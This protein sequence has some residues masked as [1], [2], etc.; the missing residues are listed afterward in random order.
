[1]LGARAQGERAPARFHR[2]AREIQQHLLQ[3]VRIAPHVGQAGVIVVAQPRRCGFGAHELGEPV[4]QF[5]DVH[6]AKP[7]RAVAMQQAI[8]QRGE[9]VGLVDDQAGQRLQLDAVDAPLQQLRRTAQ[10]GQRILHLVREAAQRGRQRRDGRRRRGQ[11]VHLDQQF[12]IVRGLDRQIGLE[13][14][15]VERGQRRLAQLH[16]ACLVQ[17]ALHLGQVL[18]RTQPQRQRLADRAAHAAA[19]QFGQRG[20]DPAHAQLRVDQGHPGRQLFQSA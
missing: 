3:L 5:V 6:R 20:I 4:Q 13:R 1:M 12:A 10:A 18:R 9:A 19:Q 7:R 14:A 15:L 17:R 2:V 11:R 8:R 16:E